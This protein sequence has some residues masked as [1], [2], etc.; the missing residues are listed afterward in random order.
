MANIL[1]YTWK[2]VRVELLLVVLLMVLLQIE[3]SK[4]K[5]AYQRGKSR[6]GTLYGKALILFVSS[7]KKRD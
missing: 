5:N 1:N 3:Q 6:V 4:R 7:L 2:S